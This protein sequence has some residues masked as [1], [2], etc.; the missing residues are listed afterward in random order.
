MTVKQRYSIKKRDL[1]YLQLLQSD[2]Q[3][4]PIES[5]V[6]VPRFSKDFDTLQ[7]VYLTTLRDIEIILNVC[8][9]E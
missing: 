3:S 9:D 2:A 6:S 4:M 5:R 8:Y 1:L 7:Y